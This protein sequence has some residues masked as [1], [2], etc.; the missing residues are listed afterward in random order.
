MARF[1]K[2][3]IAKIVDSLNTSAAAA[4]EL[5]RVNALNWGD[6]ASANRFSKMGKIVGPALTAIEAG[7]NELE[8]S[9]NTQ[10]AAVKAVLLGSTAL[11]VMLV[12]PAAGTLSGAAILFASSLAATKVAN[13][14]VSDLFESA[15]GRFGLFFENRIDVRYEVTDQNIMGTADADLIRGGQAN[16]TI[17][18]GDDGDAL[19]GYAG[20]DTIFGGGDDKRDKL[21]GGEGKD[22]LDGGFGKNK[23]FG[24]LIRL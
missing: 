24:G 20:Q 10:K 7:L 13:S 6:S 16:D 12:V 15:N 21:Y 8:L 19:H 1:S 18:G 3:E 22:F 17:F 5:A 11:S 23:L 2:K 14:I 9:G 4:I